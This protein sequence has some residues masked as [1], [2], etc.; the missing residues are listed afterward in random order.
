MCLIRSP[1]PGEFEKQ[2]TVISRL[3][4]RSRCDRILRYGEHLSLN[5]TKLLYRGVLFT[6]SFSDLLRYLLPPRWFA[7]QQLS[8]SQY[9][10]PSRMHALEERKVEHTV[11]GYHA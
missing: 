4:K 2:C 1:L 3:T 5:I 9:E 6:M 11:Q 8:R 7:V 10:G